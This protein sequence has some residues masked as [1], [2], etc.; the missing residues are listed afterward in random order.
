MEDDWT[1][2]KTGPKQ[3]LQDSNYLGTRRQKE[4]EQDQKPPG[5]KRLERKGQKWDGDRGSKSEDHCG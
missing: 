3:Q 2:T 5:G 1:Y 4:E